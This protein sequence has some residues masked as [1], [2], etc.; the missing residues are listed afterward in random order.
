L[1]VITFYSFKGGVGR[2]MALVNVAADL[3]RRGRKVL[4]VDFDLEAPGLETYKHLHPPQ[5]HPGI[6]EYVTEFRRT[7]QVPNLRDYLYEAPPIG[8]KGGQLWVMPAGR[9]DKAYRTALTNL[10]WKRLY[11]DQGG[12]FLFEDTKKGW[13]EELKPDYVLIDS[14]TG[15]TDVLGICT[16]QLPDSVVLMFTPNEQNLAG[17]KN[18]CRDIRREETE[19]LKKE[20]HL[21][22]VAANVPALY[23]EH[24]LLH[25]RLDVFRQELSIP[26]SEPV[27]IHHEET[28]RM[29]E[30]PVFVL[31]RRRSRLA[32]EYQHLVRSLIVHNPAD[33][34]GALLF[35]H[36]YAQWYLPKVARDVR[37]EVERTLAMAATSSLPSY[38]VPPLLLSDVTEEKHFNKVVEYFLNDPD[39]LLQAAECRA[40]EGNYEGAVKIL[41][42]VLNIKPDFAQVLFE[43]A[44]CKNR[45]G[46]KKDAA[47]DLVQYL[48]MPGVDPVNAMRAFRELHAIAPERIPEAADQPVIQALRGFELVEVCE[49][50][51][52]T[53]EGLS[54]AI[55]LQPK[56]SE[57]LIL[58][59]RWKDAIKLLEPQKEEDNP[60]YLF[61]LA[62]A[63][64]GETGVLS[65]ELCRSLLKLPEESGQWLSPDWTE[66]LVMAAFVLW[67]ARETEEALRK[68]D[69]AIEKAR[70]SPLGGDH[71]FGRRFSPWRYRP[72][73]QN[74]FLEDCQQVRRMIQGEPLRPV[75][76]GPAS[77]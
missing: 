31:K 68:V 62:M 49:L 57:Y 8:K 72:V 2:T 53:E 22:F 19:G 69:E 44:L 40:L 36:R 5:P 71:S 42:W 63:Y 16:R 13:E 58:A 3:V 43:R 60:N 38:E 75:F 47:N 59:K 64:W 48:G 26:S 61:D 32:R 65:E 20:I 29:L 54:R 28:L 37:G 18:V 30:Q 77:T 24:G 33:R 76:L 21:H 39:V 7:H 12:F 66:S 55:Q 34:D 1:Y 11:H 27:I 14:R 73:F 4:V 25:R 45:G 52:D 70:S 51:I 15:D 10:D 67:G 56:R 23:D 6:V 41:D 50:L 74:Q 35:L 46:Y 9:R 17:L